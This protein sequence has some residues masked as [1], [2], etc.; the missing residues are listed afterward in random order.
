M[1]Q[2][3]Q[4]VG[5]ADGATV[6]ADINSNLQALASSS[7][8]AS[9]PTITW[10]NQFWFDTTAD[11]LKQR[12]KANTAWVVLGGLS[13]T[14]WTPWF[15]GAAQ[16]PWSKKTAVVV[17]KT[18]AF[19]IDVTQDGTLF[20]CDVSGGGFTAWPGAAATLGNGFLFGI[21]TTG[22]AT[23]AV[24]VNPAG[25]E[26]IE[27]AT[28]RDVSGDGTVEWFRCT[29][30]KFLLSA[31]AVGT[32]SP[33]T[34]FSSI[35]RIYKTANQTVFNS[36]TLVNDN[37]LFAALA[38]NERLFFEVR[39]R[40]RSNSTADMKFAFTVPSGAI[41]RW[42]RPASSSNLMDDE[43]SGSD[44][45]SIISGNGGGGGNNMIVPLSGYVINGATPGNLQLRWAQN[46]AN[47]NN[48]EVLSDS[49]LTVWRE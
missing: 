27:G 10:P 15:E 6:R 38:A 32:V 16:G 31:D 4:N 47:A 1:S 22:H 12:D 33:F 48:T 41:I 2:D 20:E 13:G 49:I 24:T 17:A 30:T 36:T 40:A 37:H 19:N 45:T 34:G 3:D 46:T 35:G 23:N 28:T 11:Q 14:T 9:A 8:G 43:I 18:V 7:S 26:Q 21:K 39:L 44:T 5:N 29:G 42:S 25:A